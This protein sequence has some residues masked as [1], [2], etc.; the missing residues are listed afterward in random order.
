MFPRIIGSLIKLKQKTKQIKTRTMRTMTED[1]PKRVPWV[2][3]N[4]GQEIVNNDGWLGGEHTMFGSPVKKK[5]WTRTKIADNDDS[6]ARPSRYSNHDFLGGS[7]AA[8]SRPKPIQIDGRRSSIKDNP[9]LKN[10]A[11]N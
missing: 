5:V 8:F 11:V 1:G 10:N 7:S 9:F 2:P 3:K 4:G 6:A